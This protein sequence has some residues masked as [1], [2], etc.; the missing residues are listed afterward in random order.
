ML[1]VPAGKF[2]MGSESGLINVMDGESPIRE[3]HVDAF[4]ISET[5]VTNEEFQQFVKATGYVTDAEKFGNSFVFRGHLTN[6]TKQGT[7]TTVSGIPWWC[8]VEGANWKQPTGVGSGIEEKLDHPVVHVSWRDAKVYCEW[9]GTRLPTEA[10]WEKAARGGLHQKTYP[11]GD[12]FFVDGNYN[13]NIWQGQFPSLNTLEDGCA[14]TAPGKSYLPNGYGLYQMVGN[15]WEWCEDTFSVLGRQSNAAGKVIK[16]G[17]FLCHDSYCNRYRVS[18]RSQN[19]PDSST[20]N[21]GFRVVQ[22]IL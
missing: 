7:V 20:S 10:E 1:E 16:G 14:S 3:V 12:D 6:E 8:L 4:L 2:A 17:S 19:T 9:A 22:D 15:V 5:T 18:A 13:C 11:W 21:M